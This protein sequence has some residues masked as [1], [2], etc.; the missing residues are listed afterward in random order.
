[1][2]TFLAATGRCLD[3]AKPDGN[4]LFRA[5]SKQLCGDPEQH[6]KLREVIT[7]YIASN[8]SLFSGWT[9][10][11]QSVEQRVERMRNT[12]YWGGHLEIKA[13]ATMF[14]KSIYV[15]SDTLILGQCRWTAFP[16]FQFLH[17]PNFLDF[18]VSNRKSWLEIA[19]TNGCHYDG[20]L[21]IESDKSLNP[22]PLTR[23]TFNIEL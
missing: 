8:P 11:N 9:T 4:C 19:Y 23:T 10:D 22:P 5:L 2:V 14:R 17:L 1:M 21:P 15:A 3:P 7:D 12:G 16:P 13:A 18:N 6:S 20:V